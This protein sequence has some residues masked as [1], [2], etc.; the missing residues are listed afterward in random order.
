MATGTSSQFVFCAKQ[1]K[2]QFVVQ[3][4]YV[5]YWDLSRNWEK[6]GGRVKRDLIKEILEKLFMFDGGV[7]V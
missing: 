4:Y 3:D 6:T 7:M 2:G 5:L 1:A